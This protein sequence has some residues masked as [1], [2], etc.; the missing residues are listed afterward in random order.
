TA[1][2]AV[3]SQT[4]TPKRWRYTGKERDDETNLYYHGAR[5]YAPWLGR[6]TSCDPL[7]LTDGLNVYAAVRSNPIARVD[8]NGADSGWWDD[9]IK[10]IE[11][12]RAWV[13]KTADQAGTAVLEA[14]QKKIEGLGIKN[15]FIKDAL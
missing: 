3:R 10:G 15:G 12:A 13:K 7:G 14:D 4:E 2:Q 8:P 6:W 9:T 1:Y 11:S 5:Y